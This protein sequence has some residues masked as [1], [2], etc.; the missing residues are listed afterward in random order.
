MERINGVLLSDMGVTMIAGAY[1]ELLTPA[2]SKD[3]VTNDDPRKDGIAV[4][5]AYTPPRKE[6][7]V[8]LSF[9]ICGTSNE[10]FLKKYHDFLEVLRGGFITLSV[11][12]LG[13]SYR[14]LY[15]NSTQFENYRLNACRLAVK[16]TEPNPSLRS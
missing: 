3:Y 10:D 7:E 2:P 9:L 1:A 13:A 8:T 5:H 6:R 16:F 14:L 11:P 12:T 4:D 15:N